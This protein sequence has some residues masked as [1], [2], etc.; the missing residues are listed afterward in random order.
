MTTWMKAQ[1]QELRHGTT[2]APSNALTGGSKASFSDQILALLTQL[3]Q[4]LDT[5]STAAQ[6][7]TSPSSTTASTLVAMANTPAGSTPQAVDAMDSNDDGVTSQSQTESNAPAQGQTMAEADALVPGP[8]PGG[9]DNPAQRTSRGPGAPDDAPAP[10]S[11]DAPT[12]HSAHKAQ[13]A[14]TEAAIAAQKTQAGVVRAD[15]SSLKALHAEYKGTTGADRASLQQQIAAE[16]AQKQSD[17][18]AFKADKIIHQN[19][20]AALKADH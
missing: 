17:I 7:N 8:N 6:S 14:T 12:D 13:H 16:K 20:A 11:Q 5:Q 18:A 1:G 15:T 4:Q 19:D 3:Q 2:T 10:N 9:A